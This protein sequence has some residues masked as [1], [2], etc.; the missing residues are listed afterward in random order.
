MNEIPNIWDIFV[1]GKMAGEML[2]N[3]TS[4]GSDGSICTVHGLSSLQ[5]LIFIYLF[6]IVSFLC[7]YFKLENYC[8]KILCTPFF[9]LFLPSVLNHSFF[10]FFKELCYFSCSGPVSL[11]LLNMCLQMVSL[12]RTQKR[13]AAEIILHVTMGEHTHTHTP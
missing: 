6:S 3:G 8:Y 11:Q 7:C 4:A 10:L 1:Y 12:K 13:K 9:H 5:L 2:S